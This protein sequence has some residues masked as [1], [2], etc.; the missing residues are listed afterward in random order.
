MRLQSWLSEN[1]HLFAERSARRVLEFICARTVRWQK[2][3]EKIPVRHFE[4]GVTGRDGYLLPG[5]E[6]GRT[7][8]FEMRRRIVRSGLVFR[9]GSSFYLVNVAG[10]LKA[11]EAVVAKSDRLWQLTMQPILEKVRADFRDMGVPDVVPLMRVEAVA[12]LRERVQEALDLSEDR[13]QKRIWKQFLSVDDMAL[14][15][16]EACAESG[17]TYYDVWTAK[18][19]KCAKNFLR[20]CAESQIDAKTMLREVAR[21]WD[22][23]RVGVLQTDDGKSITLFHTVSFTEFFKWRRQIGSWLEWYRREAPAE[24]RV[25]VLGPEDEW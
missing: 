4:E 19:R 25:V 22:K 7:Q 24:R 5:L 11:V 3:E 2:Y 20:Y 18:E 16:R 8:Q 13:R 15:M 14:F 12:K 1:L 17:I 21:H 9:S 23:F 10:M 6:M